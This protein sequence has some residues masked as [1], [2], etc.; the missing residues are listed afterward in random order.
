MLTKLSVRYSLLNVDG[1]GGIMTI[2]YE[3]PI[4]VPPTAKSLREI[5]AHRK[6]VS[7]LLVMSGSPGELSEELV[8]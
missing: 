6:P 3:I 5:P 1:C 7:S 8:T 2:S 4:T